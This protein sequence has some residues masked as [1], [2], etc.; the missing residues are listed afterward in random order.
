AGFSNARV[1]HYG[2]LARIEVPQDELQGLYD[3]QSQIFASIQALGFETCDIDAEGLVS[4]KLNR[5]LV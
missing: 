4:G 2:K 3:M 5:A 1:R